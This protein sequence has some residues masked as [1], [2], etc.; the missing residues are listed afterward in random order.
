ML[1]VF[2]TTVMHTLFAIKGRDPS[3][4]LP[5]SLTPYER[6]SANT[7]LSWP[8]LDAQGVAHSLHTVN[9]ALPLGWVFPLHPFTMNEKKLVNCT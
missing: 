7:I 1:K 8:L 3:K 6:H 4:A 2:R 5:L 9:G